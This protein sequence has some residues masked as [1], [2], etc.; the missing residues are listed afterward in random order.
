[1]NSNF[2]IGKLGLCVILAVLC[3]AGY[4]LYS[5]HQIKMEILRLEDK[6]GLTTRELNDEQAKLTVET[7]KQTQAQNR[8]AEIPAKK[9]ELQA[10]KN[11]LSNELKKLS[12]DLTVKPR[13]GT[14]GSAKVGAPDE[15]Q[16]EMA[17]LNSSI[18]ADE[19]EIKKLNCHYNCMGQEKAKNLKKSSDNGDWD[20]LAHPPVWTCK[21][22]H[23]NFTDNIQ[24]MDYL[25]ES[26]KCTNRIRESQKKIA[27]LTK[28]LEK[29]LADQ[30]ENDKLAAAVNGINAKISQ[31]D[32]QQKNMDNEILPLNETIVETEKTIAACQKKISDIDSEIKVLSNK[33]NELKGG[34]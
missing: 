19:A 26:S 9:Q 34:K 22:H 17:R 23:Y 24:H 21:T 18:A 32:Q 30:K 31:L 33:V 6:I 16:K 7:D 4:F 27:T 15:I 8:L 29:A 14:K 12:P 11:D 25:Y 13:I 5:R 28:D 3:V 20:R 2:K 1:M 10:A